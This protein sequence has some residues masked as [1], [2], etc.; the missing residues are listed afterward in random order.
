MKNIFFH[1]QT[2]RRKVQEEAKLKNEPVPTFTKQRILSMNTIALTDTTTTPKKHR[3]DVPLPAYKS[4]SSLPTIKPNNETSKDLTKGLNFIK[5]MTSITMTIDKSYTPKV[6]PPVSMELSD[7]VPPLAF[8]IPYRDRAEHRLQFLEAVDLYFK[9][10]KRERDYILVFAHQFDERP[11][12]RGAMKN[13]GFLYIKEKYPRDYKNITLVFND[14]DTFPI[15]DVTM[16]YYKTIHGI[17]KHFYGVDFALGGSIAITGYDF[18]RINGFP[19]YWEWGMEDNILQN[20]VLNSGIKI[21]RSMMEK[22]N[23]DKYT[24]IHHGDTRTVDSKIVLKMKEDNGSNGIT[25]ITNIDYITL[26]GAKY[27]EVQFKKW[28]VPDNPEHIQF[29]TL[30]QPS[31]IIQSKYSIKD[32]L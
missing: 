17:V 22:V 6:L 2:S 8:I 29:D 10:L 4:M 18:E 11:F 23:S 27:I 14:V 30:Y 24:Q 31:K 28:E 16:D 26:R 25:T 9:A 12:N 5:P 19:N 1:S 13:A 21:D 3:R 7:G 15:F 32:I 20:R